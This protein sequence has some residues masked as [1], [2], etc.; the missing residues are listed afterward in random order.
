MSKDFIIVIIKIKG[1]KRIITYRY[2]FT[3]LIE[4]KIAHS[5]ILMVLCR[6]SLPIQET[7]AILPR[8]GRNNG[9]VTQNGKGGFEQIKNH[10]KPR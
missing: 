9:E 4:N 6:I 2:G 5:V 1:N 7:L 10:Q 8:Y 3:P